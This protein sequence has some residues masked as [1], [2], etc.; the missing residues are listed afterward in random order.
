MH[1]SRTL[2]P[3]VRWMSQKKGSVTKLNIIHPAA[4]IRTSGTAG[5]VVMISVPARRDAVMTAVTTREPC[6]AWKSA[7]MTKGTRIAGRMVESVGRV[8]AM[9]PSAAMTAP[10]PPAPQ[11]SKMMIPACLVPDS[12]AGMRDGAGER[13]MAPQRPAKRAILMFARI[14]SGAKS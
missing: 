7:A 5:T 14:E 12:S 1:T 2:S 10:R 3:V 8:D 6:A 11:R 4:V 13:R 9:P